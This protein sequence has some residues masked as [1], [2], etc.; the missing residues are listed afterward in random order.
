MF[1]PFKKLHNKIRSRDINKMD[2]LVVCPNDPEIL[3]VMETWGKKKRLRYGELVKKLE[4]TPLKAYDLVE[5]NGGR[6]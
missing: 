5:F 4:L 6:L 1:R 2:N 3:K